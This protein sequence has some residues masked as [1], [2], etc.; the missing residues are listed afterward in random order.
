VIVYVPS[1]ARD[2]C[3]EA[4]LSSGAYGAGATPAEALAALA[5]QLEEQGVNDAAAGDGE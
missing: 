5:R 2:R 4:L 3:W 1:S